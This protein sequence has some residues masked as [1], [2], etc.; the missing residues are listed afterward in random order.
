[1]PSRVPEE[2]SKIVRLVRTPE[3]AG[4]GIVRVMG[5]E[6]WKVIKSSTQLIRSGSWSSA[7]HVVVLQRGHTF[8][9]YLDGT[10]TLHSMP[11]QSLF[12]PAIDY[13]FSI[14][15]EDEGDSIVGIT[16]ELPSPTL[17]IRS[18]SNLPLLRSPKFILPVDPMA[19][20]Q[21]QSWT[22]PDVL[23]SVSHTGELDFW[24]PEDTKI[25]L[26]RRTGTVKTG[27]TGITRASCSSAKKTALRE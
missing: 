20:G 10:L 14:P 11:P 5:G 1:M 19:W 18:Q 17:L 26:W 6:A 21:R 2:E 12:V 4:V 13:L 15:S 23:L 7:D 16:S 22:E 27:R 8:M 25:P 24:V 3:G 9:T